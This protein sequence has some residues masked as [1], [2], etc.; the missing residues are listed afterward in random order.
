MFNRVLN[1][2]SNALIIIGALLLVLEISFSGVGTIAS[3]IISAVI[4]FFGW[5]NYPLLWGKFLFWIGII[6]LIFNILTLFVVRLILVALVAIAVL[7]YLKNIYRKTDDD[8]GDV[9]GT[10][11]EQSEV[12]VQP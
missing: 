12:Y 7:Y 5:K 2:Y 8:F 3:V 4:I 1:E 10:S 6:S 9:S 11:G